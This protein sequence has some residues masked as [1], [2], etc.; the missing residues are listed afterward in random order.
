M[1]GCVCVCMEF[2]KTNTFSRF[3]IHLLYSTLLYRQT[4][5]FPIQLNL[6]G[7]P[8]L[9][10][11]K[12]KIKRKVKKTNQFEKSNLHTHTHTCLCWFC[13]KIYFHSKWFIIT[14]KTVRIWLKISHQMNIEFDAITFRFYYLIVYKSVKMSVNL[15]AYVFGTLRIARCLMKTAINIP[16]PIRPAKKMMPNMIGTIYVSGRYW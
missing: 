6:N 5:T 9:S 8:H 4:N 12:K 10:Q 1:W 2:N 14:P 16:F 3:P 13:C 7:N 11:A 15:F